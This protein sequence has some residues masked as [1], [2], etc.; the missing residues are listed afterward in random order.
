MYD[1]LKNRGPQD[2][3]R[4]AMEEPQEVQYWTQ[5]LGVNREQLQQAVDAIGRSAQTVRQHL[6]GKGGGK[7]QS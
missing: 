4:I 1:D 7:Q 6:V 2:R 5:E 3:A